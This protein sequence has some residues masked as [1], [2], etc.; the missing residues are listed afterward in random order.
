MSTMTEAV[1][2]TTIT[3]LGNYPRLVTPDGAWLTE[4]ADADSAARFPYRAVVRSNVWI[5]PAGE[6]FTV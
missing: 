1:N 4:M 6:V 2:E 3:R 5:T